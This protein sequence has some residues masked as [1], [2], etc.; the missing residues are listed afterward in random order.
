[1]DFIKRIRLENEKK[2]E[3]NLEAGIESVSSQAMIKD[4]RARRETNSKQFK[5]EQ[6]DFKS[7]SITLLSRHKTSVHEE[8]CVEGDKEVERNPIQRKHMES[9]HGGPYPCDQCDYTSF[10]ISTITI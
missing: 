10:L 4:A 8:N 3:E 7:S 1:M 5:C 2:R 9:K 6:C